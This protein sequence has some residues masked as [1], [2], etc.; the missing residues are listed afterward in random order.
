[1]SI[2][3]H[4]I[5]TTMKR[6][7]PTLKRLIL[8]GKPIGTIKISKKARINECFAYDVFLIVIAFHQKQKQSEAHTY[9]CRLGLGQETVLAC[10]LLKWK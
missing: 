4:T 8:I 6:T 2:L 9:I 7:I 3:R 10:V 5:F 1:M